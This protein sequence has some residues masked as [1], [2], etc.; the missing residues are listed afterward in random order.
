[1]SLSDEEI[2]LF[3]TDTPR[4][5]KLQIRLR[6]FF[7]FVGVTGLLVLATCL[8]G[9]VAALIYFGLPVLLLTILADSAGSP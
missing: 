7:R 1:M 5:R 3:D 6:R 9:A 2:E 8:V 4:R